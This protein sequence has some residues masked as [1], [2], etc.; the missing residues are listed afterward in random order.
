MS[1]Q[2]SAPAT[3]N[4]KTKGFIEKVCRQH[5]LV[6]K[7]STLSDSAI[8][9]I[10]QQI[11]DYCRNEET[12][13]LL[14]GT[15]YFEVKSGRM[16]ITAAGLDLG[17]EAAERSKEYFRQQ[18]KAKP[19]PKQRSNYLDLARNLATG[20]VFSLGVYILQRLCAEDAKGIAEGKKSR[21]YN[22][23]MTVLNEPNTVR[24]PDLDGTA[25]TKSVFGAEYRINDVCDILHD[26]L[27]DF[28]YFL[29][30]DIPEETV[31]A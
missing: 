26:V 18:T 15:P 2:I 27:D 4:E 6:D 28:G 29:D 24:L 14:I 22:L 13:E 9:K 23:L 17:R 21:L 7:D 10:N 19:Q 20:A 8:D 1:H 11:D 30:S 5:Y 12:V 3:K 25:T 16:V 31:E